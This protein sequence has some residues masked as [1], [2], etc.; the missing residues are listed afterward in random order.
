[1][2]DLDQRVVVITEK[3]IA[4]DGFILARAMGDDGSR[5]YRI[6]L[7]GAGFGQ[8]GQWHKA[9]DVFVAEPTKE[10]AEYSPVPPTKP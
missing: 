2:L 9:S 3:G 7:E 5:A 8:Q 1:M 10:E 4:Y 6:G